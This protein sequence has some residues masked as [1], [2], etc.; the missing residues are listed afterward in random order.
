M[1][2]DAEG[3]RGHRLHPY[4][5]L[6]TVGQSAKGL[7]LPVLVVLVLTRGGRYPLWLALLFVPAVIYHV[8]RYLTLTYH[9]AATE[10]V[11]RHGLVFRQER[12]IPYDRIDNVGLVQ[13][14]LHRL[15]GVA[16]VRLETAGSSQPEAELEVL[17]LSAVEHLRG[18]I[19]A[20]RS[21]P[22]P[23]AAPAGA[24]EPPPET[25]GPTPEALVE[26]PPGE[27]VKLGFISLRGLLVIPV[28]FGLAEQLDLFERIDV[29]WLAEAVASA[30]EQSL[31]PVLVAGLAVAAV[32]SFLALS[33][34]WTVLRFY[35][36]RLERTGEQLRVTCGLT[37]KVSATVG[38]H[39]IQLVSVHET[40]LHRLFRRVSVRVETAGGVDE[41]AEV[42]RKWFVP[43]LPRA[44]VARVLNEL[45]P[46]LDPGSADWRPLAPKA[47]RRKAV[48]NVV[49]ALIVGAAGVAVLEWWGLPLVGVLVAWA[50]LHAVLWARRTSYAL[51]EDGLLFRTGVL[52]RQTTAT[53]FDK[54]Q[55][56]SVGQSPFDRRHR[57]ATLT[58]D[59]AASGDPVRI[60]YLD[61][62]VARD[63]L[64]TLSARAETT[65]MRW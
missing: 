59:T 14:P 52:N 42:S 40:V 39:R 3:D 64:G 53:F 30:T 1:R 34:G 18:R 29:D 50:V 13:G 43:V 49:F 8:F 15:A 6:F 35:G 48:K 46:G 10:V 31:R 55:V 38:R 19:L 63:L 32:L 24:G 20:G 5:L 36:Y 45:R 41:K 2:P 7:L 11:V 56:V 62:E 28:L 9:F 23:D 21:A 47:A 51:T 58:A 65:E 37:T 4:T 16:K 22:P 61:E 25:A 54:V 26:L 27:L 33:V 57:M 60:P 12:H 44:E 17:S